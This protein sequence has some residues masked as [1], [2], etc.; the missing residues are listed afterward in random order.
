MC[1]GTV[2]TQAPS[3]VVGH[4][5]RPE[6]A[7]PISRR[8]CRSFRKARQ[9]SAYVSQ[10]HVT[11]AARRSRSTRA[12]IGRSNRGSTCLS[13]SSCGLVRSD[14]DRLSMI[15]GEM[16][17]NAGDTGPAGDK[18]RQR[19]VVRTRRITID[20]GLAVDNLQ[21]SGV[22]DLSPRCVPDEERAESKFR[23]HIAVFS[24]PHPPRSRHGEQSKTGEPV[25][26]A[27]CPS[28]RRHPTD[29]GDG[30]TGDRTQPRGHDRQHTRSHHR[31]SQGACPRVV[32]A[33]AAPLNVPAAGRQWSAWRLAWSS[34]CSTGI[35]GYRRVDGRT[36]SARRGRLV[37]GIA[38]RPRLGAPA[39]E[40][41]GWSCGRGTCGRALGGGRLPAGSRCRC[42]RR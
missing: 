7:S 25:S 1:L 13:P 31:R 38:R 29:R 16:L 37:G 42:D 12:A 24:T 10:S 30:M 15:P 19:R 11:D 35:D 39:R 3:G 18:P 23:R 20:H 41:D 34:D 40:C 9:A 5:R 6:R 33:W 26:I 8:R 2:A 28:R 17:A 4:R 21:Q 14:L 32:H 27:P 36:T 22:V